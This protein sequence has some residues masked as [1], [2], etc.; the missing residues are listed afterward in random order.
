MP[1]QEGVSLDDES[2]GSSS[3]SEDRAE[4]TESPERRYPCCATRG[5]LSA[6]YQE[7]PYI[8]GT[9][10]QDLAGDKEYTD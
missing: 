10:N 6:Q 3:D 9:A 8:V 2:L 4:D 1:V 5:K 7:Y